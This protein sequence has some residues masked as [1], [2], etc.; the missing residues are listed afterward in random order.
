MVQTQIK[1]KSTA[2]DPF[3]V[4][5]KRMVQEQIVA[6]G[7]SD[8]RIIE[9]MG[10]VHRHDFVDEAL[11]PQAYID[12]PLSIGEGQTISQPYI[13]ALMTQALLLRGKE[14]VL[15]IGTGCGYQTVILASTAGQVYTIERVKSLGMQARSRFKN[16]GLRNIVMRIGDGSM[17][18]I[19][20]A[21]F[22]R[23]MVTCA[24]PIV[25]ETLISQLSPGGVMI[26]PVAV[27]EHHQN[28]LRITKDM[29]GQHTR[30]ED[31]GACHFVKLVG[32]KGYAE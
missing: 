4:A 14:K 8:Q 7:I 31:L 22:D 6:R 26:V 3:A 1:P 13:V 27:N 12:A 28:L 21:P 18:W 20:A 5:R 17:G 16:Y 23:I 30:T 29:A 2:G 10:R 11:K 24:A 25:P 15:E 19:E 32:K 9:V